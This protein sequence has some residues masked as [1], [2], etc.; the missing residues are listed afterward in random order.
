[1]RGFYN[2]GNTCYF[3]SAIQCLLHMK[4][5]SMYILKTP[6][7]G[8]CC[9][10]REYRKLLEA[11]YCSDIPGP[12]NIISVLNE[13]QIKFPRFNKYEQHDAQDALFCIIDILENSIP[14]IKELV[15][16]ENTQETIYNGGKNK[17]KIPFSIHILD[18]YVETPT[19]IDM[20]KQSKKWH[21]LEDYT[22]DSGKNH[23]VATTRNI[24]SKL[25]KIM[26]VSFDKKNNDIHME[27]VDNLESCIIHTGHQNKGHYMSMVK[28]NKKWFLQDDDILRPAEFPTKAGYYV[29]VYNLKTP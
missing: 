28:I 22:D 25:P 23:H 4:A 18:S 12:L 11:Y 7:N 13:F 29:L 10:T 21:V 14:Y 3:N 24:F 27:D 15:Y 5:L 8:E 20:I 17:I 9:F 16:G 1:M 19:V 6:Y 2:N 26:I